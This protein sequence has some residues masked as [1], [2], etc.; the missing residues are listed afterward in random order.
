MKSVG[1]ISTETQNISSY[2]K[3]LFEA[4]ISESHVV[5]EIITE[6]AAERYISWMIGNATVKLCHNG[7]GYIGLG[8]HRYFVHYLTVS[9]CLITVTTS[10]TPS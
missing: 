4:D 2:I 10:V 5:C 7:L 9:L 1:M 6:N 3:N 8:S